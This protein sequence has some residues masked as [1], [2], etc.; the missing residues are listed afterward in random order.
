MIVL[1]LTGSIGM[2]KS[3]TAEF[4]REEGIPVFDADATVHKLY[5]GKAVASI[6]KRFPKAIIN[7]QVSRSELASALMKD[8][9]GF[10]DLE[11]IIHPL[12]RQEELEFI[13]M[14][15][16]KGRK[17]VVLDIP[18]LF[19][20]GGDKLCDKTIVVTAPENVQKKRVLSRPGMTA[21]K[22]AQLLSRQ[23]SDAD[24]R[25]RADFLVFTHKGMAAAKQQVRDIL[26]SLLK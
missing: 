5:A 12:V 15:R 11:K 9:I 2:G 1:G 16:H 4:F 6:E 20:S 10:P 25:D 14:N 22:F 17:I 19:E 26:S 18:L 21:E 8:P 3:T 7:G 24:K 13:E 23:L